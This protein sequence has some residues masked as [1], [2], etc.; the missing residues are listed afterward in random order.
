MKKIAVVAALLCLL[1]GPARSWNLPEQ[2]CEA[3]SGFCC[4]IYFTGVEQGWW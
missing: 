4:L 1:A 3:G 2:C